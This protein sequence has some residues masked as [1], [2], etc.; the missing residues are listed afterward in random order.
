M[1]SAVFCKSPK[2]YCIPGFRLDLRLSSRHSSFA[3]MDVRVFFLVLCGIFIVFKIKSRRPATGRCLLMK[4]RCCF[5]FSGAGG[6]APPPRMR[7][8]QCYRYIMPQSYVR[9][10]AHAGVE[11]ESIRPCRELYRI[12]IIIISNEPPYSRQPQYTRARPKQQ[13][14]T[15]KGVFRIRGAAPVE[16]GLRICLVPRPAHHHVK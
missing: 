9:L 5:L 7:C 1:S 13:R 10:C 6:L 11:P 16:S 12:K 15:V 2:T 3:A 14:I 8:P 4:R